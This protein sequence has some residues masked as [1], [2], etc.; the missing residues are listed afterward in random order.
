MA[1]FVFS[2]FVKYA[3]IYGV[4]MQVVLALRGWPEVFVEI[5]IGVLFQVAVHLTFAY[6]HMFVVLVLFMWAL[7]ALSL[8]VLKMKR[9]CMMM[10]HV[11]GRTG[12][13]GIL[14]ARGH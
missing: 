7:S 9:E 2:Y 8:D 5:S 13:Q 11:L 10:G 4:D 12:G 3:R 6:I 14:H 1:S